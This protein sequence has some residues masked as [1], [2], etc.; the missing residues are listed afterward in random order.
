MKTRQ[1]LLRFGFN[2]F[3][4]FNPELFILEATSDIPLVCSI[5]V[6]LWKCV[7]CD[8]SKIAISC[9]SHGIKM[10]LKVLPKRDNMDLYRRYLYKEDFRCRRDVRILLT[11]PMASK[12]GP[13]K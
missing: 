3:D 12:K 10:Y 2:N 6:P 8:N 5:R 11:T 1:Y 4:S 9:V 7:E 13:Y